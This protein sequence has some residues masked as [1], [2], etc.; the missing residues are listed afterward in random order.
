VQY[1]GAKLD[2]GTF[3]RAFT[4]DGWGYEV[5]EL[6]VGEWRAKLEDEFADSQEANGFPDLA[7]EHR[8]KAAW[9]R[10]LAGGAEE[11]A[12]FEFQRNAQDAIN[13]LLAVAEGNEKTLTDGTFLECMMNRVSRINSLY[14]LSSIASYL[15]ERL[16]ALAAN[17]KE[18][19]VRLWGRTLRDSVADFKRL[20]L[21]KP[22]LIRDWAQRTVSIPGLISQNS[23]G[24]KSTNKKL[25]EKLRVGERFHLAVVRKGKKAGRHWN[26]Q[27]PANR[28][29]IE[30]QSYIERNTDRLRLND[31]INNEH[32]PRRWL[33]DAIMLK[34]FSRRT[35]KPWANIAWRVL[36]EISPDG[37]PEKHPDLTAILKVRNA[38]AEY[39]T[40]AFAWDAPRK[41]RKSPSIAK[42]DLREAISDAFELLA[43]GVSPRNR[44]RKEATKKARK[45][46]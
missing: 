38:R 4:I 17:E 44:R 36:E 12:Q 27:T 3:P 45:T 28:L 8:K 20:A 26:L 30:L 21:A 14:R 23:E 31:A 5:P 39:D 24:T 33:F 9:W 40:S 6:G 46:L 32:I 25:V 42:S 13:A 16:H 34:P 29:A 19:A 10:R 15:L 11:E 22:E 35:W 18:A 41:I 43:T 1:E 7:S 2:I 37:H